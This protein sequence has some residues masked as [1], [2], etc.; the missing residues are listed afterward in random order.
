MSVGF[1]DSMTSSLISQWKKAETIWCDHL[2]T[3]WFCY[4]IEIA[5]LDHTFAATY[6][7]Y[8]VTIMLVS[9][10]CVGNLD[11][12]MNPDA[13][14]EMITTANNQSLCGVH[15]K[16]GHSSSKYPYLYAKKT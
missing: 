6:I 10:R 4:W 9:Y 14:I 3:K 7:P 1:Q 12:K 13:L 16:F 11:H 8:M 5:L 2:S 15:G